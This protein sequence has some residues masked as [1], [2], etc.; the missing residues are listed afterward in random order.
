MSE[1]KPYKAV[2]VKGINV[3]DY[4]KVGEKIQFFVG[5]D[6]GKSKHYV[7]LCCKNPDG[8]L[9]Y[10]KTWTVSSSSIAIFV[11]KLVA[12]SEFHSVKVAL[13]SSGTY[14]DSLRYALTKAHLEVYQVR[15]KLTHDMAEI[16]D[17][18]PSKHD[19]KDAKCIA[20]LLAAGRGERWDY[21]EQDEWRA[22]LDMVLYE[23]RRRTMEQQRLIGHLESLFGRYW[24]TFPN[25]EV[26]YTQISILRFLIEQG[27]PPKGTP[28]EVEKIV[29]KTF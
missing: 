19:S 15:S 3:S 13:E 25:H 21:P 10:G 26:P 8:G 16:L 27:G 28:E 5:I 7:A 22:E 18:S 12:I 20:E 17:G 2:S 6:V 1:I 14:G 9:E 29:R 23:L 24:P 4:I 11:A